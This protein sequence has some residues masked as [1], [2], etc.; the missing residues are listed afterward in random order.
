MLLEQSY[1]YGR[2]WHI[3]PYFTLYTKMDHRF[4]C[5]IENLLEEIIGPAS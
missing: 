3:N 2:K 1:S 5:K 4:K